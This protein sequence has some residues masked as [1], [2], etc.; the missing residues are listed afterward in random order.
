MGKIKLYL[1]S[2]WYAELARAHQKSGLIAQIDL[3]GLLFPR[4]T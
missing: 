4:V 1:H 3:S 2:R